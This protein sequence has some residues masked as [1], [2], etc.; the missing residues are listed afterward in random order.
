MNDIYKP[1]ESSLD[2][3]DVATGYDFKLYTISAIGLATFFGTVLAGGLILAI[4]YWRLG[5]EVA[6][7]NSLLFSVM[8][9][10]GI[11]LIA[12]SIPDD[13]NLPNI[14]FTVIQLVVMIQIAKQL[15][16]VDINNHIDNDGAVESNWKAFG[17]SLLVS[18]ALMGILFLILMVFIS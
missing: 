11:L 14:I 10:L 17:I 9:T 12:Y 1:P 2:N 13:V 18:I 3:V 8:A 16:G 15:Q 6:A 4:N 7:R 5:N